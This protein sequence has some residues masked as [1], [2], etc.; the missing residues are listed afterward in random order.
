MCR[1]LADPQSLGLRGDHENTP[2]NEGQL[3]RLRC[4]ID[5][6]RRDTDSRRQQPLDL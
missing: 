1:Q 4:L 2:L 5:R 6:A 3:S